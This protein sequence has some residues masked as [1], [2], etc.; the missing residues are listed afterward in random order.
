[1]AEFSSLEEARA[2]AFA[3]PYQE[4]GIFANVTVKPFKQVLP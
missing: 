4:T 2:W 3:D 1:V